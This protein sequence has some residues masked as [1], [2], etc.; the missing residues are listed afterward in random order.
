M[1]IL[2][3]ENIEN[4]LSNK[5]DSRLFPV[6]AELLLKNNQLEKAEVLCRNGIEKHPDL[7]EGYFVL[8]QI[9]LKQ[10]NLIEAVK[11]L[12]NTINSCPGHI[13]S[14][15]LLL[16]IGK[17][18]LSLKEI[19]SSHK[20]LENFKK[21]IGPIPEA[22][23][24]YFNTINTTNQ[25]PESNTEEPF[26]SNEDNALVNIED[27]ELD[28]SAFETGDENTQQS[29][30]Q[31]FS[32]KSEK[33]NE[34]ETAAKAIEEPPADLPE[35]NEESLSP[36]IDESFELDLDEIELTAESNMDESTDL[37]DI[38]NDQTISPPEETP[39]QELE[40]DEDLQSSGKGLS[41]QPVPDSFDTDI[42]EEIENH[43]PEENIEEEPK[44]K[45]EDIPEF[46]A[47]IK[48]SLNES[49]D[50]ENKEGVNLNIPIPTLT[51]VEVLKNQKLYDQALE[52]LEL[53]EKRS[54]DKEK[55][56]QKKEEIIKLKAETEY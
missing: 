47:K 11:Q 28:L 29:E 49:D 27:D 12:Q 41:I 9:L 46:N 50:K 35:N 38:P 33:K 32:D 18:N 52:I 7:S 13:K 26:L 2:K 1:N 23:N 4:Y 21:N 53:L 25:P 15:K 54:S 3:L 16:H 30:S 19:D 40:I 36:D 39:K 34:N 5:P 17:E 8:A 48:E 37:K 56:I 20:V 24:D 22:S 31:E 51:F 14:H 6:L 42:I 45:T 10:D 44:K 43:P 55:I